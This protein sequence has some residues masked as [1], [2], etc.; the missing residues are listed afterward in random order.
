MSTQTIYMLSKAYLGNPAGSIVVPTSING[1]YQVQGTATFVGSN[2]VEAKEVTVLPETPSVGVAAST[3][4][5]SDVQAPF[6]ANDFLNMMNRGALTS[7]TGFTAEETAALTALQSH[8]RS[9][10]F[11]VGDKYRYYTRSTNRWD[12]ATFEMTGTDIGRVV[13]G[14]AVKVPSGRSV[15]RG[16]LRTLNTVYELQ[17]SEDDI[18]ASVRN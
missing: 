6:S 2:F 5:T 18:K 11:N 3:Q 14:F 17:L 13:A 12:L 1:I 4:A 9:L 16:L 10:N 7:T 8:V 15:K